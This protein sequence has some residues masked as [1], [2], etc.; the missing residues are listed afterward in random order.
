MAR[1]CVLL[2]VAAAAVTTAGAAT[3]RKVNTLT[4]SVPANL[5]YDVSLLTDVGFNAGADSTVVANAEDKADK[6]KGESSLDWA[7]HMLTD[8]WQNTA[9]LFL[10]I[11]LLIAAAC[12]VSNRNGGGWNAIYMCTYIT[13]GVGEYLLA[14]HISLKYDGLPFY[15]PCGVVLIDAI[16]LVVTSG[17]IT[18][19][20]FWHMVPKIDPADATLLLVPVVMYFGLNVLFYV[21]VA[22]VTLATY[23]ITFELQIIVV[24]ILSRVVFSRI[25]TGAQTLACVG[26]II[27][28]SIQHSGDYS[29]GASWMGLVLPMCMAVWAATCTVTCEYVFKKGNLLD[30]NVQNLYM[31][32]FSIILGIGVCSVMK[33]YYALDMAAV[34]AGLHHP[35]V[36]VLLLIRALFGIVVSRILKYMDSF[37]KTIASA[38]CAPMALGLAPFVV[39][40]HISTA[41]LCAT[42]ITYAASLCYWMNP[43]QT[44][45][46]LKGSSPKAGSASP[47]TPEAP[48]Q[49]EIEKKWM[50]TC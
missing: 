24:A 40:E 12:L 6:G 15:V 29:P 49:T 31:Y 4:P 32:G 22:S 3:Q 27:G 26:V 45:D 17:F 46:S 5:H 16:K 23:A 33:W 8:R 30:I 34:T 44:Q 37:S 14:R 48:Y 43:S 1:F 13:M 18:A 20:G 10:T 36:L 35:E 21:A 9:A 19:L 2:L 28:A 41:T 39:S 38:L 11:L 42:A 50:N 47:R 25:L 7:Y